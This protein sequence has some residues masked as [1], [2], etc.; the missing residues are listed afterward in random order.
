[1]TEKY[2]SQLSI[3][4]QLVPL[5]SGR[6]RACA[7][8]D[9][10]ALSPARAQAQALGKRSRGRPSKDAGTDVIVCT[11]SVWFFCTLGRLAAHPSVVLVREVD[12]ERLAP[13]MQARA[14]LVPS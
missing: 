10:V 12:G 8:I 5:P 9:G 14:F 7:A 1:M 4:P 6:K 13:K 2:T 3:G 11:K